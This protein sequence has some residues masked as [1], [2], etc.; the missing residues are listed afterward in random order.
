MTAEVQHSS[1]D[2]FLYY[3][4]HDAIHIAPISDAALQ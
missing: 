1:A 4:P 2:V 3:E